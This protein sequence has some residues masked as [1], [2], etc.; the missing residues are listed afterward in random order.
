VTDRL[1]KAAL[2]DGAT[3]IHFSAEQELSMLW[4]NPAH[5]KHVLQVVKAVS[6]SLPTRSQTKP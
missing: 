2:D 5:E 1:A 4:Y 6:T 3:P